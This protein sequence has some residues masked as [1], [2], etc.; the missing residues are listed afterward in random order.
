MDFREIFF[1]TSVNST[2][3]GPIVCCCFFS[4]KEKE[5]N[6]MEVKVKDWGAINPI[7]MQL[8]KFIF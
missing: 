8:Y 5:S 2:E 4:L 3:N 1:P 7:N 6:D